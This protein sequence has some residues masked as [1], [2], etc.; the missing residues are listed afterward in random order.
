MLQVLHRRLSINAFLVTDLY[1]KYSER[2]YTEM[3]RL[4]ASGRVKVRP[5]VWRGLENADIAL[6]ETLK[7][8]NIGKSVVLVADDDGPNY[9]QDPLT[10]TLSTKKEGALQPCGLV[11]SS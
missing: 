10:H 4:L 11:A 8:G 2:F 5:H 6:L 3:P 1:E 9:Y 7:G